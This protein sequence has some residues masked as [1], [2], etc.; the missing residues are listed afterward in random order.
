MANFGPVSIVNRAMHH[1]GQDRIDSL[2]DA[3]Q[4]ARHAAEAY[5]GVRQEVL[6]ELEWNCAIKRAQ[7]SALATAPAFGFSHQ[8][9]L[10]A[11]CLAVIGTDDPTQRWQIEHYNGARVL[12]ANDTPI[13]LRYVFDLE[14][15]NVMTA[16]L[17]E[18]I[19]LKLA[20]DIANRI[21]AQPELK[22]AM[23]NAYQQTLRSRRG[24][25]ARETSLTRIQPRGWVDAHYGGGDELI[26]PWSEA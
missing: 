5:D 8:H 18:C 20:A 3:S 7:L 23:M 24:K 11:D 9:A 22:A 1:L 25:D 14:D 15:A 26:L 12:L 17:R 16:G 2:E 6:T 21:T 19:A 13:N 10:P 4:R